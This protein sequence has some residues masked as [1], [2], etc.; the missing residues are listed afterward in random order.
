M[1]LEEIAA[2]ICKPVWNS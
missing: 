1:R 2:A